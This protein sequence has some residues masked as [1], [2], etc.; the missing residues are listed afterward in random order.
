MDAGRLITSD[1][2][3]LRARKRLS[4]FLKVISPSTNKNDVS[5]ATAELAAHYGHDAE[6]LALI[7]AVYATSKAD[8]DLQLRYADALARADRVDESVTMLRCFSSSTS[9]MT[10]RS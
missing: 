10:Q 3:E 5:L 2:D 8:P 1:D 7:G 4:G 6:S 9:P